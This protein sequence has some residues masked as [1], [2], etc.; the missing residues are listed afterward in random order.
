MFG[1]ILT[2]HRSGK[3]NATFPLTPAPIA[4]LLLDRPIK[5]LSARGHRRVNDEHARVGAR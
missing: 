1:R 2:Y 4:E 5:A 3:F